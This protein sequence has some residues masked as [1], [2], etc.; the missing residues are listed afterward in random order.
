[1]SQ[2]HWTAGVG[3]QTFFFKLELTSFAEELG[4]KNYERA[5]R[6]YLAQVNFN[7]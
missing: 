2:M 3:I 1:M 7:F 5:D 6:M 4:T